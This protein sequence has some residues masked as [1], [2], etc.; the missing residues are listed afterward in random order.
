MVNPERSEIHS[1]EITAFFDRPGQLVA[2]EL[3]SHWIRHQNR[4]DIF[5]GQERILALQ[6]QLGTKYYNIKEII[7]YDDEYTR[8]RW[9][10]SRS[11]EIATMQPGEVIGFKFHRT[12]LVF[13]KTQQTENIQLSQ[14]E[15]IDNHGDPILV[16]E[17]IINAGRIAKF[18]GLEHRTYGQLIPINFRETRA[19]LLIAGKLIP[20]EEE[21]KRLEEE[22]LR[23]E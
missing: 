10:R 2:S 23:D 8:Q 13:I 12:T 18:I 7:L 22:L 11:L 3:S 16:A 14:L 6:T 19:F 5:K 21:L 1:N 15:Q 20:T 17:R 4:R 9:P